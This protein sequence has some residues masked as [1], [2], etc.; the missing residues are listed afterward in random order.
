VIGSDAISLLFR[1]KGDTSDAKKAFQDLEGTVAGSTGAFAAMSAAV[2][3][4]GAAIAAMAA[5]VVGAAVALYNLTQS[6]AEY[7]S[8]VFDVQEKTG[9]AAATLSTLKFN[10]DN[11]GSS[12]EA[13]GSA[14]AKFAK[15]L[16]EAAAGNEKAQKTLKDLGVTSTD[17]DTALGQATKTIYE[18][19]AGTNQLV[20]AQK[21]FGKSGGDLIGTIKQMGGDL[22]AATK[23]AER[24]GVVM[25]DKD[26]AAA[27]AFGDALGLLSA[28]AK[29]AAV[30]FT[31]ELMPVLVK[32]FTMASEWYATN[33]QEVR[34][35]GATIAAVVGD[36]ARGLV[37][38]FNFI[39]ENALILRAALAVVTLGI[40]ELVFGAIQLL[41]LYRQVKGI[42]SGGSAQEG[43]GQA[44]APISFS[45][46]GG[47]AGGK[48]GGGSSKK[49]D[50]ER[51]A[52]DEIRA[53]LDL[54]KMVLDE[55]EAKY[56]KTMAR[57]R[58]EFKKTGDDVAF[59]DAA[60]A[61]NQ[62]LARSLPAVLDALDD[63]ERKLL[64]DPTGSQVKVL[65]EQQR[66]RR[67]EIEALG[68]EDV[69]KNNSLIEDADRKSAEKRLEIARK[70]V[71]DLKAINQERTEFLIA[72][73]EKAWEEL[74]VNAVGNEE[75][76][77]RLRGEAINAISSMLTTEKNRR[78]MDL[79]DE[80]AA[81]KAKIDQEVKDEAEKLKIFAALDELY[82]QKS[83]LAEEEFQQRL[84]EIQEGFAIPVL[85][86]ETETMTSRIFGLM[87][88]LQE[89]GNMARDTFAAFSQ[90]L[91][92]MISDWVLFGETGPDA[93]RKVTASVLAG[94]AAQAAVKSLFYFAEGIAS[95]FWNP[96]AAAGYF[97]A[98]AIM[99]GIAV[100]S[101][102][103]GRAIAGDAFKKESTGALGG[104]SR[105]GSRSGSGQVFSSL[106]DQIIETSR[107][108]P[109]GGGM[110]G[111]VI[112]DVTLKIVSTK[113]HIVKV[114][115]ENVTRNGEL[116]TVIIDAAA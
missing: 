20:L 49:S 14:T 100:G 68:Q 62:E 96:A 32:Y 81:R 112:S 79:E 46:G 113:D 11:A 42:G 107:N 5:V 2:P 21:A 73:E 51:K 27:D 29:V 48:G 97:T 90:G 43:M 25:S 19:E 114:V 110:L 58:E 18:A 1:A 98:S 71:D 4:A 65:A 80:K 104:G 91:G 54:Q 59:I 75:E 108:N 92:Q 12:L 77:N 45:P 37:V 16:G 94:L 67:Q 87:G 56:K 109:G 61:A 7:A 38:S 85:D 82:K 8:A 103:A 106:D 9:L 93:M 86:V 26:L 63:L 22:D 84:K 17:L 3:I 36:F 57:V 34:E 99:G 28:Q 31:S 24:L 33:K 102:I 47:G 64:K 88:P 95:L 6:A 40:S 83:L 10:A 89:L 53:Q 52:N 111:R 55:L 41:N 70:L 50:A 72:N 30:A 60:N 66:K 13:V 115:K 39:R 76:Q 44:A 69:D 101:A 15:L 23:E 35:W 78:L 116:R 105:S 74:I